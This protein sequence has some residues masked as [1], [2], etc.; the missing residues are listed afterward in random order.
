VAGGG[1]AG[2]EAARVAAL[3]GHDVTLY[4]RAEALGGQFRLA[5]IPPRKQEIAA[6]LRYL[7]HELERLG[8]EIALG[9]ELTPALV[10]DVRPDAVVVATGSRPLEP[11]LPGAG[12]ASIV[13]A[14][15]VL[16]GRAQTGER[17][18]VAGGGQLGCETAEFLH[19]QGK[20]VTLLEMRPEL[21]PDEPSVPRRRLLDCLART[22]VKPLTSARIVETNAGGIVVEREG[23]REVLADVDSIVLALGAEPDNRLARELE[24]QVA[25]LH[26]IGDAQQPAS[27]LAAI[28]AGAELGRRL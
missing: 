22:S 26:V 15:D 2:L 11:A 13:T 10:S 19:E 25:E 21:A 6:Y 23:R 16:A 14:H 3:R 8:V 17:V 27:A 1:P 4:E 5:S 28:A 18:L 12:S 9:Q 7:A 24:G 20:Q